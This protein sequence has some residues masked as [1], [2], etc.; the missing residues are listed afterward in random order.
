MNLAFMNQ[1]IQIL[2]SQKESIEGQL[3][4]L[5]ENG[6]IVLKLS[7]GKIIQVNASEINLRPSY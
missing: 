6:E 2:F 4:G 5:A 1:P 7:T 3:F